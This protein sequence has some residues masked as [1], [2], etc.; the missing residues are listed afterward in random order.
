MAKCG[1]C[2]KS[3]NVCCCGIWQIFSLVG[4]TQ[5]H[6][7]LH[8]SRN[9]VT[10]ASTTSLSNIMPYVLPILHI[11]F[12][13]G[14][15][16]GWSYK[17]LTTWG[18]WHHIGSAPSCP[19]VD[20]IWRRPCWLYWSAIHIHPMNVSLILSF[21]VITVW[22]SWQR[23]QTYCCAILSNCDVNSKCCRPHT[24]THKQKQTSTINEVGIMSL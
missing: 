6:E 4:I 9:S 10:P 20:R 18:M 5:L 17:K 3:D 21:I 2:D 1:M 24:H 19:F 12:I 13:H 16:H 22:P 14:C 15:I 8:L 11:D 23:T 7:R